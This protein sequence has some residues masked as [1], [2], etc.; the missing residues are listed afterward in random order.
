MS[1]DGSAPTSKATGKKAAGT[2]VPNGGQAVKEKYGSEFFRE[3]GRKGGLSIRERGVE[4]LREI[5]KQGG[6]ATKARHGVEH[7][8]EIGRRGGQ[9]GKGQP[10]PGTGRTATK[11]AQEV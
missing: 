3:I 8:S 5:G 4:Y 7:Y 11:A 2:E 6:E 9:R 10:K 1:K